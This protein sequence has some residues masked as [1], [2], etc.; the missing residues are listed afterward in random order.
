MATLRERFIQYCNEN[1]DLPS[2][3]LDKALDL[4]DTCRCS[5]DQANDVVVNYIRGLADDFALDND[6]DKD[7]FFDEG[8]DEEE[9]LFSLDIFD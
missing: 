6:L 1:W 2:Y 3:E 9:L 5:L 7:W 8:I 4:M